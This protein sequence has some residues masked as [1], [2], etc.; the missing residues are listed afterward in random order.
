M[1]DSVIIFHVIWEALELFSIDSI[2][3]ITSYAGLTYPLLIPSAPYIEDNSD[4][5]KCPVS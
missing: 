5:L 4:I 2:Q 1:N 3:G